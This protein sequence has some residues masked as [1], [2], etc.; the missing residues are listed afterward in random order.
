MKSYFRPNL[1][2]ELTHSVTSVVRSQA[3]FGNGIKAL[4]FRGC[5]IEGPTSGSGKNAVRGREIIGPKTASG[6]QKGFG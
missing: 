4:R 1:S 6:G 3:K 5:A 2:P